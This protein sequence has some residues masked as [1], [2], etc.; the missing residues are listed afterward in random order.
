ME[1]T[2]WKREIFAGKKVKISD[3]EGGGKIQAEDFF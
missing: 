1:V 2:C 3:L